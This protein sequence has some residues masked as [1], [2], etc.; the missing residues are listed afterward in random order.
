M[1]LHICNLGVI[2]NLKFEFGIE[3]KYLSGNKYAVKKTPLNEVFQTKATM[4]IF[5]HEKNLDLSNLAS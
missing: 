4:Y 5:S 2:M 3:C 1:L